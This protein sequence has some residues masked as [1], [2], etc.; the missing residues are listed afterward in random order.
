MPQKTWSH[1]GFQVSEGMKPGSRSFRYFFNVTEGDQKKCNYCIWIEDDALD[2]FD[3]SGDF[4]SIISSHGEQWQ[5]WVK[6]KLDASDFRD[7][8]LRHD[9]KGEDEIDL[10]KLDK[11]LT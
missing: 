6:E 7:L 1:K 2:R 4:K 9:T 8:V 3:P 5:Q 10:E 11:K